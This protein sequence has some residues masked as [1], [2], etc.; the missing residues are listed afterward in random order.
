MSVIDV[1]RER[2]IVLSPSLS[3][4]T[5]KEDD[6]RPD[7]PPADLDEGKIIMD[8]GRDRGCEWSLDDEEG[9][10]TGLTILDAT[11]LDVGFRCG[12][13]A[14]GINLGEAGA[15]SVVEGRKGV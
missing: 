12:S 1:R 8:C 7:S 5:A 11:V 2:D 3:S 6:G 9:R 14:G 4:G 10:E 13:T 15:L